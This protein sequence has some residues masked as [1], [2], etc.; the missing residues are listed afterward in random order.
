MQRSFFLFLMIILCG[1]G[2]SAFSADPARDAGLV[3]HKALYQ[4]KLA[5]TKS[6]SQIVNVEGQMFYEWQP[7]CEAWNSSHRFKLLYEYADSKPLN[8]TSDFS[9]FEPFDGK[10]L[11][12]TS[13]RKRDGR[14]FEEVRG[15]ATLDEAL[16]TIPDGLS[17]DLPEGTAFPMQHTLTLL[18]KAKAGKKFYT[19]TMFDGSDEEG[20]VEIN[21]FIRGADAE[22][23][24]ASGDIDEDLLGGQRWKVRLAFFPLN[25]AE[26]T[27]DYEMD[28]L[29]HE[30]GVIT[31]MFVEY[32]DFSITQ[33][34]VALEK[35]ESS[36][37]E[38]TK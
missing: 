30:N 19:T 22:V 21:A 2:N 14:V 15:S 11:N 38:E 31:N 23:I 5:S 8:V 3:P 16:Y 37:P 1:A 36:C 10:S 24:E 28:L 9:T 12:F 27:S 13:Q 35:L 26:E 32:D 7:S 33:N 34:L 20:P 17:Y 4:I 25:N 6:G 18:E 29:L